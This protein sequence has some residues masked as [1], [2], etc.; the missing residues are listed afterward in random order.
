MGRGQSEPHERPANDL[1]PA[2]CARHL[3]HLARY[4][5]ALS[6]STV[7]PG[8]DPA[9]HVWRACDCPGLQL[10]EFPFLWAPNTT[11]HRE[12]FS[13]PIPQGMYPGRIIDRQLCLLYVCCCSASNPMFSGFCVS[14]LGDLFGACSSLCA[15]CF[16]RRYLLQ[17]ERRREPDMS[18][19]SVPR[20][21][22]PQPVWVAAP[23][24]RHHR[25]ARRL[26]AL[27]VPLSFFI[28][29]HSFPSFP[30]PPND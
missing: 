6:S 21:S 19:G 28:A 16:G 23:V 29:F 2:H 7:S 12:K 30:S 4:S 27:R 17:S 11:Y 14:A 3:Q 5:L 1:G 9:S 26:V 24:P 15:V 18:P 13:I 22:C 10:E 8:I 25:L 20:L